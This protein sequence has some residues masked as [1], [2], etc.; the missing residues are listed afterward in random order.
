MFYECDRCLINLNLVETIEKST[1]PK[2]NSIVFKIKDRYYVKTFN[3]AIERDLA[4][5]RLKDNWFNYYD[6]KTN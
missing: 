4:Y 1:N 5:K 3:S 2:S 6:Y